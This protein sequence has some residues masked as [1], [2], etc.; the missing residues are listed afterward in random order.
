MLTIDTQ[1]REL[2]KIAAYRLREAA[3]RI[4]FLANGAR[5]PELRAI[6]VSIYEKLMGDQQELAKLADKD[7]H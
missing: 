7:D 6:F 1:E 5:S 2:C 3:N 4:D